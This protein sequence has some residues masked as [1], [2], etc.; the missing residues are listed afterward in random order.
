VTLCTTPLKLASNTFRKHDFYG[1]LEMRCSHIY[2]RETT[3]YGVG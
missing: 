1:I 2:G 3:V